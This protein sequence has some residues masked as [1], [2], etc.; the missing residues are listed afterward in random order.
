V[1]E[2]SANFSVAAFTP[3]TRSPAASSR[4]RPRGNTK[5][6]AALL[7]GKQALTVTFTHAAVALG[8]DWVPC[9]LPDALSPFEMS[10]HVVGCASWVTTTIARFDPAGK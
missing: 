2:S 5:K 1:A 10:P 8:S 4:A 7:T 6:A 3:W 9:G